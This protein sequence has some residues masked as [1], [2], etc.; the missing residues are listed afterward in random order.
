M[1]ELRFCAD[2]STR[3]NLE[4]AVDTSGNDVFQLALWL[5]CSQCQSHLLHALQ[6][7]Q[8]RRLFYG[9]GDLVIDESYRRPLESAHDHRRRLS[10]RDL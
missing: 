8:R 6:A 2:C 5:P 1:M 9:V 4:L 10:A 3:L 7:E